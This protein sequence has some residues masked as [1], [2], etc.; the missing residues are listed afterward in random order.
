MLGIR[1][2]NIVVAAI[3]N[4]HPQCLP[5]TSMTKHLWWLSQKNNMCNIFWILLGFYHG[6]RFIVWYTRSCDL[7]ICLSVTSQYCVKM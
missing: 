5:I 6:C 7:F 3:V 4:T 2:I 1:K